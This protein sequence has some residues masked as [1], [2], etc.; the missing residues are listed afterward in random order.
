M[1][2]KSKITNESQD[3]QISSLWKKILLIAGLVFFGLFFWHK[4]IFINADLGRH[5]KNGEIILSDITIHNPVLNSNFYSYAEPDF[6]LINHHWGSGVIFYFLW[7]IFGF[8]GLSLFNI[9]IMLFTAFLFFRIA[10]KKSNFIFALLCLVL[11]VPLAAS[12]TEIR[13]EAF[14]YLL[15]GIFYY[16]LDLLREKKIS[17][18]KIL[19]IL[20]PLQLLWVNL[21]LFFIIGIFFT[22]VFWFE[23]F[24]R[25]QLFKEYS[26]LLGGMLVLSLVNPN[27]I[28][29]F[30]EPLMILRE[31][32]YMIAENQSLFFMHN[33]FPENGMYYHFEILFVLTLLFFLYALYLKRSF[34][35]N[36]HFVL[37]LFFSA[38][39]FKMVRGI[40]L[41]GLIFM[42]F[43]SAVLFS[44]KKNYFNYKTARI[45]Q[46]VCVAISIVIIFYG[47]FGRNHYYSPF[48]GISG[49][50]LI[51]NVNRSAEFIR[52]NN[53]PGP[54]FNNYDI[55]G[56]FIFNLFPEY[57][58]FV[59]NRPE[60]YSVDFFKKIYEP[61]QESEEKWKE[62]S[63]QFG[64]NCIYFFRHDNTPH[65]QPFL[66]RRINDE[67]WAP[68]FVDDFSIIFLKRS[69]EN[70]GLIK[71]FELPESMF[72]AVPQ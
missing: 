5:I 69:E 37:F 32:G 67:E 13:P 9:L 4:I 47:L 48:K 23:A 21:H 16:F 10:E 45:F 44:L 12:R 66:I 17:F 58:V 28:N 41:W 8:T 22:G 57:K 26:I 68:V 64:F 24:L 33:R 62:L 25:K 7:K 60:A 54:V 6:P 38:L 53:I 50:G 14:S 1:K 63:R 31:Y 51:E 61:M 29:G 70:S 11:S 3:I 40:P 15:S 36:P 49:A 2:K 39:S 19:F 72:S 20:L 65:A 35:Y 46:M 59:D 34:H 30:L 43:A 52:Q 42:P 27:G 71:R 55:G 56:Y 18:K